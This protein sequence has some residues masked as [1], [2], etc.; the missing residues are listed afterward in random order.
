MIPTLFG[1]MLISFVI[2]QF[3]PG[4]PVERIIAQLQGTDVGATSR[5]LRR[6]AATSPAARRAQPGGG[7]DATSSR[8]R[9]AQ[10]LDPQFIKQLE[11]QFGFDKPAHRALRQDAVGLRPLRFRQE[12][13]PRRLGAAADPGEAAGL[14]LA[15]PV[16][17]AALLRDL[18]PARHP[19]GGAATARAFDIWTSAVVIVGYAIPGFLFAILLIVLFAGGSF[20]QIFP[21]RGLTSENWDQLSLGRQDR[22]ITSGTSRCRSLAMALGAFATSTLLTKNSFL[23]EIR[24]QYVLT[25]RMKGL[26]ERQVL[27]GHVFRNAM[28]IVIAG[29]PGRLHPRLLRRLAADRDDLL[30]RRARAAVLRVDRQPRLSGGV[31]EPLHLLAARPG[32]E[33][34]LRPHLHL[35]RSAHRFRDAGG[36]RMN[37]PPTPELAP[38]R[39]PRRRR[40][41]SRRR[42][43][44]KGF[45]RLSPINRAAAGRISRPTGAATGRSGSSWSCSCS[46]LFA[47]FIANDRPI[48]VHYKGELLFPVFVDY[49][50]EKFGGFLAQHRLP[51]SGD[52]Q[53]DRGERLGDLAADPLLLQHASTSTCRCRRRRRRPGCSPTSSAAP[54]PRTVPAARA[55]AIIE[56]NW[57]GTDDQGRDVRRAADLRLPHLGAVRPH[58]RRHLV[59]DRRAR[60]ARC[61]AISAAGS[62]SCSSASSRSGPRSRRSIC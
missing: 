38:S 47:E 8:Y 34:D 24:K 41:R 25:A 20:W 62:T 21:L 57:L 53:G 6:A 26:T 50:E 61:R 37:D 59:G 30:A 49:P 29:F 16:D 13:F 32:G 7:A 12:L 23:D 4:G 54:S 1:I 51:R 31:R 10:G 22:S 46:C 56:W 39:S 55:A 15:R 35:D 44:G 3:A 9:G 11:Q 60:R 27:Y 36:V 48:L 42:C 45:I 52:R 43:R 58:P 17:D 28:L 14:D 5:D 19:Q 33:P 18:D 40:R 2:V